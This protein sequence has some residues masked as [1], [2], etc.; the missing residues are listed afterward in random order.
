MITTNPL[1]LVSL[2]F[3]GTILTYDHPAGIMHRAMI[4]VLNEAGRRGVHWCANS[5]REYTDQRAVIARSVAVGLTNLPSAYICCESLVFVPDGKDY[6]PLEPWNKTATQCLLACHAGV[7]KHLG[8]KLDEIGRKYRPVITA[9]GDLTTSFLLSDHEVA[10][11]DLYHELEA[12]LRGLDDVQII[13]NGGWVA[14]NPGCLGKGNALMAYAAHAGIP[15][16]A[17][18]AVGDHH[19]DL[20]MLRGDTAGHVG[21]PGDAIQEVKETVLHAG[22]TVAKLPG[23]EGTAAILRQALGLAAVNIMPTW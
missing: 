6:V 2:D 23:A 11:F 14:V 16:S 19:N 20:T 9:V 10:V 7:Q 18:L 3:D 1:Q 17:I 8:A 13:R 4:H 12:E 15:R 21:C 5:G 22:G